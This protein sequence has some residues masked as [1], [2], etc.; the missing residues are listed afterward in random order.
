MMGEF[1]AITNGG[2]INFTSLVDGAER[3]DQVMNKD[4][5]PSLN[6]EQKKAI[7]YDDIP[8]KS[9]QLDSKKGKLSSLNEYSQY[10]MP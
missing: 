1:D 3:F 7:A 10:L 4:T 5:P 6:Y 9:Q 8:I 2:L